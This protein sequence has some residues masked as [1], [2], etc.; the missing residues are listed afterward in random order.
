MEDRIRFINL[1]KQI[2]KEGRRQCDK[3]MKGQEAWLTKAQLDLLIYIKEH[4]DKEVHA[5][6]LEEYFNLSNPTI[7]G[8]L[9]RLEQKQM[10]LRKKSKEGSRYKAI[11]ITPI[12]EAIL[13][14][15]QKI[16]DQFGAQALKGIEP[17]ELKKV[18][19][20]LEKVLKNIQEREEKNVKD[21]K[22]N[23]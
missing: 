18:L 10:I 13:R 19:D 11:T 7:A 21:T 1:V 4:A 8:I 5:K 20:T 12:G 3:D 23:G 6:D 2:Q 15:M 17:T 9:S 16:G 22:T 14:D